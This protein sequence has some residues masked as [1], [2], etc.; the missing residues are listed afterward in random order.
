MHQPESPDRSP[1]RF[2]AVN[3]KQESALETV[4]L[5]KDFGGIRALEQIDF[6]VGKEHIV[7]VIGP[8][9]AGKTTFINII[10]GVYAPDQGAVHY[11]GIDI[12]GLPAQVIAYH[13]IARTFQLEEL[14]VSL[15]V[16][17]NAMIGCYTKSRASILATGFRLP[18]AR[19]EKERIKEQAIANLRL[20]GLEKRSHHDV[21]SLPLG[22]RKL[23]GIA[24]ALGSEPSLLF[25]DEPAGGLASHEID[26]LTELIKD[27]AENGIRVLIVEHNMPFVIRISER[28]TVLD[29][30]VKIA[31]GLPEEVM[32]DE[33]VIR[34]Y[35][36]GGD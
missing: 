9:G 1:D 18:S 13:G 27:L 21:T 17:E 34:A 30:G 19:I 16:L 26:R 8:N 36:G 7:S 15:T 12:T 14:F 23:M 6:R 33:K 20:V 29:T 31:E 24:R 3:T 35:L 10:A 11:N 32:Q 28:V 2:P 25:L 4:G 22:E 5:T